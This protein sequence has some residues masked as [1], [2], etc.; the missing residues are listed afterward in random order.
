MSEQHKIL[1]GQT[2][3]E[4][5]KKLNLTQH[6]LAEKTDLS[7]SYIADLEAGRYTPSIKSLV[8]ISAVLELDLNFLTEMTEIQGG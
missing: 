3:A 8:A 6:E 2:I 5:R 1:I 7:R 4:K